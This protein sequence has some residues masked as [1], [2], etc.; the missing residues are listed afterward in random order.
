MQ[1]ENADFL[2]IWITSGS[3]V[4]CFTIII[5]S[6]VCG[7]RKKIPKG[8]N[9][10]STATRSLPDLPVDSV[11]ASEKLWSNTENNADTNSD[12]YA[13][14]EDANR[15]KKN[16]TSGLTVDSSYTPSQTDDSLSPYARLKGDHSYDQLQQNEHPYAQV[17][18]GGPVP[19]TSQDTA[20]NSSAPRSSEREREDGSRSKTPSV[21]ESPVV[22]E[23]PAASAIAGSVPANH[24]LPYMTPPIPQ[25]HF[26]GDSQDSGKG[27]TSISVREPLATILASRRCDPHYATVS[28]DSDEMYAAID[29]RNTSG[30]ET[31]AQISPPSVLPLVIQ[32]QQSIDGRST[33]SD[34]SPRRERRPANSPLPEPPAGIVDEMYAKVVKKR[35]PEHTPMQEIS[36]PI[37]SP[38]CSVTDET[39][40]AGYETVA[41]PN[42]EELQDHDYASLS[43]RY[44]SVDPNYES[45]ESS[46]PPYERVEAPDYEVVMRQGGEEVPQ[47]SHPSPLPPVH[48]SPQQSPVLDI[49]HHSP[50]FQRS[51][52]DSPS[53]QP[54][55]SLSIPEI[56]QSVLDLY[57]QVNKSPDK[58]DKH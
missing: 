46:E 30:S 26:S 54:P 8:N 7:C 42:Y 10:V 13:T 3:I 50:V 4:I 39:P 51:Q 19:S 18:N 37:P 5:L 35:S 14:V 40:L 49:T 24:D 20:I 38:P 16:L 53:V 48:N 12:L 27:Y 17:R 36:N 15:K 31:Y 58:S 22:D 2:S 33:S 9:A 1:F 32:H 21:G 44:E 6:C 47:P 43:R 25:Q 56:P 45:V 34:D 57:A 28:D 52:Q 55:Q 11:E 41:D 29:E 23:I